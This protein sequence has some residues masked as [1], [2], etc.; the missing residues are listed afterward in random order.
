MNFR[1]IVKVFVICLL[2]GWK[3]FMFT[4]QILMD[5]EIV[6]AVKNSSKISFLGDSTVNKL[7]FLPIF[8]QIKGGQ[9]FGVHTVAMEIIGT[10]Q[11]R[12]TI[13][14]LSSVC[15]RG[16]DSFQICFYKTSSKR[17]H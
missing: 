7:F 10:K 12:V 3:A 11:F 1:P 17:L 2:R 13:K 15:A 9:I 5:D 16:I 14:L 4:V 6:A 8:D